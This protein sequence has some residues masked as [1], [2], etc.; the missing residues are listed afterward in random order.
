[1]DK[2]WV[3][4]IPTNDINKVSSLNFGADNWENA[5]QEMID[6]GYAFEIGK[7]LGDGGDYFGLYLINPLDIEVKPSEFDVVNKLNA[8]IT[9]LQKQVNEEHNMGV[10]S[11]NDL[12]EQLERAYAYASSIDSAAVMMAP[13]EA[14]DHVRNSQEKAYDEFIAALK[15][16]SIEEIIQLLKKT[17]DSGILTDNVKLA[18]TTETIDLLKRLLP[19]LVMNN[20]QN[21][22]QLFEQLEREYAYAS[23]INSAAV[24]MAPLEAIDHVQ[25]NQKQA[26]DEFARAL[27][28]SSIEENAYI[29]KKTLDSDNLTD[30]VKLGI[31][32][33]IISFLEENKKTFFSNELNSDT[34]TSIKK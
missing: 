4:N 5:Y 32:N 31:V 22:I 15:T 2:I 27:K 34:S 18:I 28:T 3:R 24:M 21:L 25:N 13:L 11:V 33:E 16:S 9:D 10:R 14:I 1:M 6:R 20:N 8:K 26:Y 19:N 17:F 30:N 7:Q 12:F 23:S 29:L